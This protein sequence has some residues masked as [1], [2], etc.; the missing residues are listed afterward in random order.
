MPD[1]Q[2]HE[3]LE[4]QIPHAPLCL[5]VLP[6][7]QAMGARVNHYIS[8]FR[9]AEHNQIK[10]DPAF[11]DYVSNPETN[12]TTTVVGRFVDYN[13]KNNGEQE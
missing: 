2:L 7:A 3:Q 13:L 12:W 10:S 4:R 5:A 1:I 9:K 6:S 11:K 8:E